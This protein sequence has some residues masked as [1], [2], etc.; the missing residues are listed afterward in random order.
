M[1]SE[2]WK[3]RLEKFSRLRYQNEEK[4]HERKIN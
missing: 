3:W 4:V 2:L 1:K